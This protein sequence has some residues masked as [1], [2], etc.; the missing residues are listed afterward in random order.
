MRRRHLGGRLGPGASES[1]V[2]K[3]AE[4][5]PCEP[6]AGGYRQGEKNI[7]TDNR[8]KTLSKSK[9]FVQVFRQ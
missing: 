5:A 9:L 3:G 7:N 2:R 1:E 4:V 6:W 8:K